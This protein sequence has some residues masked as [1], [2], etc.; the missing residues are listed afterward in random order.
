MAATVVAL[1]VWLCYRGADQVASLLGPAGARIMSRLVA[2]LLLCVGV[3][4]MITGVIGLPEL[5]TTG[6]VHAKP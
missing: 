6:P 1:L 3:Q 5:V 4:I 2:F